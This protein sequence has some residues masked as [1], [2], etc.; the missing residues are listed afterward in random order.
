MQQK[1]LLLALLI[2]IVI[3]FSWSYFFVKPPPQVPVKDA[4]SSA[5]PA[6]S[7]L[8]PVPNSTPS[9]S[10]APGSDS[11]VSQQQEPRRTLTVK[12]PLYEAKFDSHG[13]AVVS[14]IIKKNKDSGRE[15]HSVSSAKNNPVPL[16][17]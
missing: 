9:G 7:P 14:W 11:V 1:R 6:A 5:S 10:P 17:L 15:I 16:E 12:T 2:S 13:A 4:S 3:L 8:T